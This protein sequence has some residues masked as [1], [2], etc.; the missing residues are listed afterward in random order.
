MMMTARDVVLIKSFRKRL[1]EVV[2][3][4]LPKEKKVNFPGKHGE[5]K[6]W[7]ISFG[8]LFPSISQGGKLW[9]N[10]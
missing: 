1:R 4:E 6:G 5:G 7:R 10:S 3:N 2:A 8:T 9:M